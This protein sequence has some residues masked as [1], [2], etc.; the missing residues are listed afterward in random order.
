M[1]FILETTQ[2]RQQWYFQILSLKNCK[3]LW[4]QK[5]TVS[6][7]VKPGLGLLVI[8]TDTFLVLCI[9]A[10]DSISTVTAL[11]SCTD[12][13]FCRRRFGANDNGAVNAVRWW[14]W[15]WWWW[16]WW[17]W[18]WRCKRCHGNWLCISDMSWWRWPW[19]RKMLPHSLPS[20]TS[21]AVK[22]ARFPCIR[23]VTSLTASPITVCH[24]VL[25]NCSYL[26][27]LCNWLS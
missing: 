17:R 19:L 16:R 5:R 20:H 24:N 7:K 11:I 6:S 10:V 21:T 15:W 1:T 22:K 23:T 27:Y 3:Y 14:W 18:L 2:G 8:I 9:E 4:I 13:T 26:S 12:I 25:I